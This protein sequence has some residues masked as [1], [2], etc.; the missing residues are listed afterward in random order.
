[1]TSQYRHIRIVVLIFLA[2][3]SLI[4]LYLYRYNK[5]LSYA[6]RSISFGDIHIIA[7]VADSGFKRELGLS[8]RSQLAPDGAML[9]VFEQSGYYAFWMK[10]MHFP[11]DIIWLDEHK[12]VIT[13]NTDVLPSTYPAT[14]S[15]LSPARYVLE[16]NAGFAKKLHI[17]LGDK[18]SF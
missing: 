18:A 4:F 13:I 1:M 6:S 16:L 12:K 17:S 2:I 10:D 8:G 14:F 9:F 3:F 5:N 7:E 11:L 15:P